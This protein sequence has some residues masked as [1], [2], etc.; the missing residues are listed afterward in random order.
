MAAKDDF[1]PWHGLLRAQ[2]PPPTSGDICSTSRGLWRALEAVF[3]EPE[4][5]GMVSEALALDVAP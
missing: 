3:K 4:A 5:A 2:G 1:Q